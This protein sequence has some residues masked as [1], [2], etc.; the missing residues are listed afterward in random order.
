MDQQ[1]VGSVKIK[2]MLT[3]NNAIRCD[4]CNLFCQYYDEWTPYGCENYDHP[5][6]YDPCHICQKCFVEV[7]KKWISGFKQGARSGDWEKSNA[8]KEA[9]I[10]CGL[11]WNNYSFR[12][13]K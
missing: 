9:A 7:K 1:D 4:I 5:E 10:K 12:Y 6:P 13:T 3:K 8:E 2:N 11:V